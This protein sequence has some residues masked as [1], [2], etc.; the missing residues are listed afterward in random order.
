MDNIGDKE[1]SIVNNMGDQFDEDGNMVNNIA[2]NQEDTFN[3]DQSNKDESIMDNIAH[4]AGGIIGNLADALGGLSN[5]TNNQDGIVFDGSILGNLADALGGLSNNTKQQAGDVFDGNILGNLADEFGGLIDGIFDDGMIRNKVED[6]LPDEWKDEWNDVGVVDNI[7]GMLS[8][9]ATNFQTNLLTGAS[10]P[11]C[12][13]SVPELY[14]GRRSG[15]AGSGGWAAGLSFLIFFGTAISTLLVRK[16]CFG[17]KYERVNP[18]SS[19]RRLDFF[20]TTLFA[21][22]FLGIMTGLLVYYWPQKPEVS[23]CSKSLDLGGIVENFIVGETNIAMNIHLS[24]Y[25]PNNVDMTFK[26]T[27]GAIE[28]KQEQFGTFLLPDFTAKGRQLTDFL[29]DVE[30]A[31]LGDGNILQMA[32]DYSENDLALTLRMDTDFKIGGFK[33]SETEWVKTI[34]SNSK[35]KTESSDSGFCKCHS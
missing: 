14:N 32:R 20:V 15:V 3:E 34:E 6:L 19:R 29:V 35:T 12:I 1:G 4:N 5:N 22:M 30:F 24:M 33:M 26:E 31:L 11:E 10:P 2:H 23:Q 16:R 21:S 28:Y 27:L 8:T 18:G 9:R 7:V 13:R 17:K 25:N